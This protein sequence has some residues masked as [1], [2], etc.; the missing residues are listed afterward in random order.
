[1]SAWSRCFLPGIRTGSLLAGVT[2][3]G[4]L[5][6]TP[7]PAISSRG[8]AG[9]IDVVTTELPAALC[10]L[11]AGFL[12]DIFGGNFMLRHHSRSAISWFSGPYPRPSVLTLA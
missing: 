4:A 2:E 6:F 10:A 8:W 7:L 9:N 5:P 3:F 11:P 12:I 1:M